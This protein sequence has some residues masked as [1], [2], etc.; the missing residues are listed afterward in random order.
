MRRGNIRTSS[1]AWERAADR[2]AEVAARAELRLRTRARAW[3][4]TPERYARTLEILPRGQRAHAGSWWSSTMNEPI[5][6]VTKRCCSPLSIVESS[7]R[8]ATRP[9]A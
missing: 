8:H 6:V 2:L 9:V 4:P 1:L 3:E 5:G 7:A